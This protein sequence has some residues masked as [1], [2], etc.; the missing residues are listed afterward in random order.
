MLDEAGIPHMVVGSFASA[1]HGE[2]RM[3]QDIDMVI[4]PTSE[5]IK[6]LVDL[7][8]RDR[9]YL[10]DA[11]EAFRS[12]S[13]FNLIEPSSG[14]KVDFVV[15]K[16]RPFSQGEFNRRFP[17]QIAGV[18]VY[19][20]TAEDTM[21]AKLEWGAASGSDRQLD[22]VV[23]IA[24]ASE[25][26]GDYLR[27]WAGELGVRERLEQALGEAARSKS[28][29]DRTIE[30]RWLWNP[31]IDVTS[32]ES[33]GLM[34]DALKGSNVAFGFHRWYYG[35]SA[36][37]LISI[38]TITEFDVE[39]GRGRPGD[40]LMLVSLDSVA[41]RAIAHVGD[42]VAG[43]LAALSDDALHGVWN[44][45]ASSANEV[46]ALARHIADDGD[47]VCTVELIWDPDPADRDELTYQWRD[48]PGELWL[49]DSNVVWQPESDRS[50]IA[51]THW[52]AQHGHFLLD[53]YL[54]DEMGRVPVGGAY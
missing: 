20:A 26:D 23:A 19:L 9:F 15:R 32:P 1:F 42:P 22:D 13:M 14:W 44:F 37:D 48:L 51:R 52:K 35:G 53:G 33:R 16:D 54:P 39:I 11:E 40:N 49:F 8:D 43:G 36:P 46:V 5:S 2:P 18:E 7:V 6:L 30:R 28:A 27:L 34:I 31:R 29:S 4:E 3:T 50:G 38:A 21:L 25:V 41:N 47:V 24:S 17:A 12:R 10:G 45:L